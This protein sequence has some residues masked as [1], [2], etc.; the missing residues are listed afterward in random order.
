[1][2]KIT[3]THKVQY[4]ETDQMKVVH[5]SNYIRWFEEARV[6]LMEKTGCPYDKMEEKGV[7][8]PVLE[9]S[10]QYKEM[11]HFGETVEISAWISSF[12]GIRLSL[13]YE[14]RRQKDQTLCTTGT[15]RHCFINGEGK[16]LSL[17]RE[18]P[19]LYEHLKKLCEEQDA[20]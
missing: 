15:S 4:Y 17:K 12:N 7:I 14:V 9:V 2:Q 19:A 20:G 8:S 5:H 11:V 10:C 1:M 3:W 16:L 13:S 18:D 6:E